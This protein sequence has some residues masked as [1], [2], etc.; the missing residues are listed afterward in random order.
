MC[1]RCLLEPWSCLLL[2]VI[3]KLL[4]FF[5]MHLNLCRSSHEDIL[6]VLQYPVTAPQCCRARQIVCVNETERPLLF[7]PSP[8]CAVHGALALAPSLHIQLTR[9]F[10]LTLRRRHIHN[11][12]AV[13]SRKGFI[14]FFSRSVAFSH[15]PLTVQSK[16]AII[17][18][19][20]L[21]LFKTVNFDFLP[22]SASQT[23]H[24]RQFCTSPCPLWAQPVV[25]V[26]QANPA[27]YTPP[28]A[29]TSVLLVSLPGRS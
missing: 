19:G 5:Y 16:S 11:H 7:A 1:F 26:L 21:T 4:F 24:K 22:L 20:G 9:V 13:F 2:S 29:K 6:L 10:A 18:T 3:E 17:P 27:V 15:I 28:T 8:G 23:T 25:A 14:H 12:K